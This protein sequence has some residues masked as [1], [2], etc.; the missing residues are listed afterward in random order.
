MV[1]AGD[2]RPANSALSS[3]SR[4]I[5]CFS[6]SRTSGRNTAGGRSSSTSPCASR[7]ATAPRS[8]CRACGSDRRCAAR[9]E[10]ITSTCP[11]ISAFSRAEPSSIDGDLHRVQMPASLLPVVG[12]ALERA[13][14]AGVEVLDR[15]RAGADRLRPVRISVRHH[16]HVV[17]REHIRQIGVGGAQR[18]LDL[19]R[20]SFL[21]SLT[22]FIGPAAPDLLP[23]PRCR[24]SE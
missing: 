2:P 13:C 12:V 16:H 11:D 4:S 1:V 17:V 6:A 19:V 15:E 8:A 14:H 5:A 3:C 21:M 22:A 24:L 18:D 10:L 9:R 23:G 20:V 7:P